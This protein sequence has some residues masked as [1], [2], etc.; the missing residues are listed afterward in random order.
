MRYM[1][2][3][4][5]GVISV[6]ACAGVAVQ[7]RY[8]GVQLPEECYSGGMLLGK[9]G[10]EGWPDLPLSRCKPDDVSKGKCWVQLSEDYWAKDTELLKLRKDLDECQRNCNN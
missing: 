2:F 1:A 8:Y 3:Y 10:E 4:L 7:Y 6:A 9:L 5:L